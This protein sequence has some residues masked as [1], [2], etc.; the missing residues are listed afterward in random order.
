MFALKSEDVRI[1]HDL[2][3][4]TTWRVR[5]YLYCVKVGNINTFE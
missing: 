2:C 3:H 4:G 1:I 5:V